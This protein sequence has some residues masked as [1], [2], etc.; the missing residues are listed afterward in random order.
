MSDSEEAKSLS[1]IIDEL[2]EKS[3]SEEDGDLAIGEVLDEFAG[4]LFGPLI[5]V[6]AIAIVSPLG[7]IPT[8]PTTM[9]LVVVLVAGQALFGMKRPWLPKFISDRSVQADTFKEKMEKFGPWVTWIDKFTAPRLRYVVTGPMKYVMAF[10][11]ILV[12]FT[13]PPLEFLPYAAILPGATLF[14]LGLAITSEDGLLGLISIAGTCG[15]LYTA[16]Q[17]MGNLVDYLGG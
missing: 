15:A 9:G 1:D 11:A 2:V 14:F 5:L 17:M 6:P 10:L 8:V 13:L 4:R 3:E 7:M 16:W 12:A